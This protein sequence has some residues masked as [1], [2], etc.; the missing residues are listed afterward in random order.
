MGRIA[1]S[2]SA[3]NARTGEDDPCDEPIETD[4]SANES[5]STNTAIF[6]FPS[7]A[8]GPHTVK[9]HFLAATR[10]GGDTVDVQWSNTMVSFTAH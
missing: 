9:K 8:P 2:F 5:A 6:I 1:I 7:I 3:Y 10:L 4:F